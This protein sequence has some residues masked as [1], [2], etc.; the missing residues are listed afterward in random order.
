MD[1]H[2]I[3]F[4]ALRAMLSLSPCVDIEYYLI[5]PFIFTLSLRFTSCTIVLGI[6]VPRVV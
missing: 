4:P 5:F 6:R 1:S 3:I 2:T